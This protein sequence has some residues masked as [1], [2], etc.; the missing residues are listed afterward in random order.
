[1]TDIDLSGPTFELLF[2]RPGLP[3][4]P[5]PAPLV[6]AYG[7]ALGFDSPRVFANFVTSVDGVVALSAAAESG[8]II[9]QNSEAD[10]FV[11]GLLRSCADAVVIGAGTFRKSPDHLWSPGAIH[12][13]AA[14]FY[15]EA[16]RRIGLAP[17]PQL[18]VVSA[19]GALDVTRPALRTAVIV[20]SVSGASKLRPQLP[21]TARLIVLELQELRL[22]DVIARL[23][24][25][26]YPRLLT[27]GGPLLFARL[28]SEQIVDELFVT[29]SPNVFGRFAND[30]RKS[31]VD[32]LDVGGV[33]LDL[34]SVRR[35][36]SHLFLRYALQRPPTSRRSLAPGDPAR[37]P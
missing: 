2:E 3:G 5:L 9:S 4:F 25:E 13:P 16:R 36:G 29:S 8:Q 34:W 23:Q 12:P 14:T 17:L 28:L 7:S 30:Q 1:M 20:T 31:L 22:A 24:R 15:A 18:V 10:R 11:M 27:E 33:A 6:A 26:G 32:G 19:S 37:R 35:H 21:E